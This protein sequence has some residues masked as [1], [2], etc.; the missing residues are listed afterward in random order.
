[1]AL[2]IGARY[3]HDLPFDGSLDELRFWNTAR[4]Q[5]SI[6]ANMRKTINPN[7]VG[8]TAYYDFDQGVGGLL[9][10]GRNVIFDKKGNSNNNLSV[11]DFSLEA[12]NTNYVESYATVVAKQTDPTNINPSGFTLN[13]DAPTTGLVT[14]YLVDVSLSSNFTAPISGSP[15]NVNGN[16]LT[17]S[18]L[19]SS[20]FYCRVRANNSISVMAGEGAPFECE[21]SRFKI[22]TT[23]KCFKL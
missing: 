21:S 4:S 19:A 22:R 7:T 10:Y 9:N 13:W 16:S 2:S 6:V 1:M 3:C 20:T 11:I 15:F 23:R 14:N 18:G 5:D 12:L 8:L 17:L